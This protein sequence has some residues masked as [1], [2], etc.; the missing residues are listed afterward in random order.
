MFVLALASRGRAGLI[1]IAVGAF[2]VLRGTRVRGG[3]ALAVSAAVYFV[4]MKF[5]IM[6]HV[7]VAISV[8]L[9]GALPGA[10]TSRTAAS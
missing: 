6:P 9:Q 3:V 10:A 4:L 2:L 8:H 1:F 7:G 5:V